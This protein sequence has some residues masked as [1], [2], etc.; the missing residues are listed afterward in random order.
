M[1]CQHFFRRDVVE[2]MHLLRT[3]LVNN[4]NVEERSMPTISMFYG[5]IISMEF[6]DDKKHHTPHLHAEYAE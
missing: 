3:N 2:K 6:F 1:I 4:V 5:I